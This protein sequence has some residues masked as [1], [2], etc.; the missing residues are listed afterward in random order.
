VFGL[1]LI[2]LTLGANAAGLDDDE[3]SAG[4]RDTGSYDGSP[5]TIGAPSTI[6]ISTVPTVP[7]FSIPDFTTI[8]PSPTISLAPA[9]TVTLIIDPPPTVT[10][11]PL[12]D[13]GDA[14]DHID[15]GSVHCQTNP[16]NGTVDVAGTVT[17]RG[18]RVMNYFIDVALVRASNGEQ[19]GSSSAFVTF[20][21]PG[22]T[23]AWS[24]PT[25]VEP[26]EAFT[27]EVT[28]ARSL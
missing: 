5:V 19:F 13:P 27:C 3:P 7:P 28:N 11:P 21:D 26:T 14:I 2:S 25:G 8:P 24:A 1:A 6:S 20:V 12:S 23:V 22:E 4:R 10:T 9:S 15:A 16:T 18:D 17:N